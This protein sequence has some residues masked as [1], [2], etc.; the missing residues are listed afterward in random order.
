ML[1]MKITVYRSVIKCVMLYRH[2]CTC[3]VIYRTGQLKVVTLSFVLCLLLLLN[4]VTSL[5]VS[6]ISMLVGVNFKGNY[7]SN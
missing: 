7:I 6:E 5:E 3:Y 4:L 1:I 2:S